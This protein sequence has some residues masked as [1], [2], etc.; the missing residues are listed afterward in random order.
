MEKESKVASS[1]N[2]SVAWAPGLWTLLSAVSAQPPPELT[3][4]IP[5]RVAVGDLLVCEGRH[6]LAGDPQVTVRFGSVPVAVVPDRG[7]RISVLVPPGAATGP[8]TVTTTAAVDGRMVEQ[9]SHAAKVAVI[10]RRV[11]VESPLDHPST[12]P[13]SELSNPDNPT[14]PPRVSK[15]SAAR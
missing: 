12:L 9:T 8:V 13:L 3:Q 1:R 4:G 10:W 7:T 11:D 2:L 5:D 15:G 14:R 6:F